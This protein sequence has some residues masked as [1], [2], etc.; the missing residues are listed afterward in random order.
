MSAFGAGFRTRHPLVLVAAAAL[1]VPALLALEAAFTSGAWTRVPLAYCLRNQR[2]SFTY[3]SWTV[4]RVKREPPPAPLVVLTGGSSAREALVSG[5][6]LARDVAALGGPRVVAY[7]LGCINQNFAET[8]A[9]AD[10]LP[11]GAWLLVGVNLGRFTA[12]REDNARQVVGRD[13]LLDS[14][15]LRRFVQRRWH[16]QRWSWT[17]LPGVFSYLT[18]VARR[19][20]RQVLLLRPPRRAYRQHAYTTPLPRRRKERLVEYWLA[21]RYPVFRRHLGDN[22]DL[23][24]TLLA[25][26]RERGLHAVVVE[27]PLNRAVVGDRFD[28][29]V[30]AYR[31]PVRRLAR[32]Y[33]AAYLD[34]NAGLDIPDRCFRDLSHL[35]EPGRRAWQRAL[36]AAL[37]E[38][39]SRPAPGGPG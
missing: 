27:L 30:A 26:C 39:L 11:R 6:G 21:T 18:D 35:L 5:E 23:L 10:N 15:A 14:P 22:L 2:D 32:R 31:E 25:R 13:L 38:L 33:G 24:E 4:G 19:D 17:I 36:A 7:D 29:A 37:V 28:A 20:G 16:R 1:L 3:I 9:V 34:V 8:L 12:D